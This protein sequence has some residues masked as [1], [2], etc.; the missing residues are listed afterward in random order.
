MTVPDIFDV[1]A[2]SLENDSRDNYKSLLKEYTSKLPSYWTFEIVSGFFKQAD[3]TTDVLKFNY[4]ENF[5]RSTTWEELFDQLSTLNEQANEN[6][7]YK[8]L[9]LARHGQGYHNVANSK[10]GQK[11]WDEKWSMVD[12]DGEITWGPDPKLTE[13]GINQAIE[14]GKAW[15]KQLRNGCEI[16]TK[17][18]TSPMS[19]SIDTMVHTW[20]KIVDLKEK[21][22]L[23]MED[24]RETLGVPSDKRSSKKELEKYGFEFHEDFRNEDN[25]HLQEYESIEHHSIR[26]N[27]A[28]QYIFDNYDDQVISITSH[29]GSIRSQLL[30]LGHR[31]FAIGTGGMIP[32][33]V[34]ATRIVRD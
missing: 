13:L 27:R 30:V 25:S 15:E 31:E 9:F 2:G 18:F 17:W 7:C 16:P 19:R 29:S 24:L 28:Y 11:A 8:V 10:Y 32:V 22:P 23:I 6:E 21:K 33:F 1:Y 5:G 3:E 26:I 20:E 4:L 34:K 14:N 12:T